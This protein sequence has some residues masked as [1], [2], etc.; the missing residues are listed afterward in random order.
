MPASMLFQVTG[1]D[2]LTMATVAAVPVLV[3]LPACL[4]PAREPR[5]WT[6]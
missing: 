3:A 6:P 4:L 1:Y 2:P 5:R